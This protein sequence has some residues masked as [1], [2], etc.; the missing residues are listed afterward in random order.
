MKKP[1]TPAFVP[2]Q[3]LTAIQSDGPGLSLRS[4]T[5]S[6]DVRALSEDLFHLRMVPFGVRPEPSWAVI[7]TE[8]PTPP[9]RVERRAKHTTLR[10]D[11]AQIRIDLDSGAWRVTDRHNLEVFCAPAGAAGF[12]G[13]EARLTLA[14][15]EREAFFGLGETTATFNKRGLIREFWNSDVLGHAPAI[16]PGLR[17]LYVSIPFALSF[18]DGRVAG[19]FWDN[20]ARQTWDLGQTQRDRWQMSTASGSIDLYL[21][22]GPTISRVLERYT[23]LTGRMPMPPRWALG[24][25]QSRYSYESRR[26]LESVAREFRRRQLPCDV[27]YCD[28][29]HMDGHRVFTFGK[30]FPRPAEMT[31]RLAR[32]GFKVVTIVNP[33]VKDSPRFDVL[34]RGR[35][36]DAFVRDPSGKSDFLGEVWPGRS[37]FPDFLRAQVR[38][39]WGT[40]QAALLKAGV[41]GIWN[42]MNEPA[43]FA[44]P[45]RTLDPAARHRTDHGLRRHHQ[46]HNVY[47]MQMARASQEGMLRAG[48]RAGTA[49]TDGSPARTP[50]PFVITRAGYAGIQRHAVLWT[51]DNSACWEH[52][53]DSLQ[54][55]LNLGLSGVPFVGSDVAGFLDNPTPELFVRWLQMAVFTPFLRNHSNVETLDQEPWAF[56]PDIEEIAR[57]SLHLRYQLIPYLYGLLNHAARTGAPIMRPML[58]HHANDP[59]AVACSDQFLLGESLL[60]APILRQGRVARSVYLPRGEWFDFWTGELFPGGVHVLRPAPLERIPLL[61]KAGTILP[62][63]Q[64]RPFIGPREP[65]TVVLHIWPR[66][67]GTLEFYDDDG[68]TQAFTTGFFQRRTFRSFSDRRGGRLE[69]GAADG[70]YDGSTQIWRIVLR[71]VT[72]DFAVRVDGKSIRAEYV[73]ELN[74]LAWD[75]P[76]V[77]HATKAQWR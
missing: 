46:V 48:R 4:R 18:R 20:P 68:L 59:V 44:R 58:W 34:R 24:Y 7:K 36:I 45:D 69:V 64:V 61:I 49:S 33:G 54:M 41:A 15:A 74:L 51:G 52:L 31:A 16:H 23:E 62:M 40:E 17:R 75:M 35:R 30:T 13:N 26:S 60:V 66:D 71:C 8:W 22:I 11:A 1:R 53:S 12:A 3:N 2:L 37:R 55:L 50:R 63:T 65:K 14:L 57:A 5:S 21:F 29:H 72:R 38:E 28:I 70:P 67:E 6:L 47:G 25:H 9:S 43:N 32:Q 76:A 77:P 19:L 39:W 73:P 56:G 10:T 27:L 42:D